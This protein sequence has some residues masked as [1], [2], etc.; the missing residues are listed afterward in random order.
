MSI[1]Y[2]VNYYIICFFFLYCSLH[3]TAGE[4]LIVDNINIYAY[5]FNIK[6][7]QDEMWITSVIYNEHIIP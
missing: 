4:Y 3:F 7:D 2:T 5:N 6:Y 1:L